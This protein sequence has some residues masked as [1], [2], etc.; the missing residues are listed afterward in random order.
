[1]PLDLVSLVIVA[2][3]A[4]ITV[5]SAMVTAL[6]LHRLAARYIPTLGTPGAW[7]VAGTAISLIGLGWRFL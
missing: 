4:V 3:G 1:M 5:G 7:V 2:A 6:R